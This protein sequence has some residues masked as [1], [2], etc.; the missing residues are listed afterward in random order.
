MV[1]IIVYMEKYA[2]GSL[3]AVFYSY[4]YLFIFCTGKF[5]CHPFGLIHFQASMKDMGKRTTLIHYGL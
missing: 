4:I 3:F 2:L 5:Y 1:Y